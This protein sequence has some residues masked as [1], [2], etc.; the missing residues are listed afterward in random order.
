MKGSSIAGGFLAVALCLLFA[1]PQWAAAAAYVATI[2]IG[3]AFIPRET[4]QTRKK[5]AST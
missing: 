4:S 3:L 2:G 5:E 1:L